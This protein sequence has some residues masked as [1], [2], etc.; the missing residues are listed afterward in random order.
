MNGASGFGLSPWSG[1]EVL[2]ANL[3]RPDNESLP[4]VASDPRVLDQDGDGEPGVTISVRGLIDGEVFVAQKGWS[5]LRP[6]SV[7]VDRIAG[8]VIWRQMQTVLGASSRFLASGPT[9]RPDP[10]PGANWFVAVRVPKG[11]DCAAV[12]ALPLARLR[13]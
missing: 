13:R 8:R 6:E 11:A 7:S 2:G 3:Q 1:W 9:T 12:N 10:A 4:T 5:E